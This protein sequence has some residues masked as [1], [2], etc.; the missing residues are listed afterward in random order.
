[1]PVTQNNRGNLVALLTITNNGN[2]ALDSLQVTI[3]GTTLGSSG[4]LLAP[5]PVTNLSPG[6]SA[7]VRLA[8]PDISAMRGATTAPLKVNLTY[9]V[10]S[11]LTGWRKLDFEFP[12]C[13]FAAGPIKST[14]KRK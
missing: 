3:A 2:I 13:E 12:Q 11:I 7:V 4:L 10:S 5:P 14:R 1:M 9:T 8:F 6:A